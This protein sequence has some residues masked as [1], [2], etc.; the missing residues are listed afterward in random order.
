MKKQ[1]EEALKNQQNQGTSNSN[2]GSTA[3]GADNSGASTTTPPS[4]SGGATSFIF[5][6][7]GG[8]ISSYYGGRTSPTAGASSN[9]KGVDIAAATGTPIYASAGGTVVT[10][11]YS[12][13]RGYYIVVSHGN[14]V[15][16]LYQHCSSISAS[17]GQYVSQ[18]QVIGYVGSTGISTGPHLHYEV[19]INGVNVDP[20]PSYM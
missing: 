1:Q 19:L 12:S 13:A 5:P 15:C 7:G 17:V 20:Y 10:S 16:T 8:Y 9:H 4:Y 11:S 2:S 18:G 3:S 6:C 14:G